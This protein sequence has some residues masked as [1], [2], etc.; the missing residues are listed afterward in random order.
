MAF[1]SGAM[2]RLGVSRSSSARAPRAPRARRLAASCAYITS[3][4]AARLAMARL[5]MTLQ[6]AGSPLRTI[7]SSWCTWILVM[8]EKVIVCVE[9]ALWISSKPPA[10]KHSFP[11]TAP[12]ITTR[13]AEMRNPWSSTHRWSAISPSR[14]TTSVAPSIV[15]VAAMVTRIRI[16]DLQFLNSGACFRPT[17]LSWSAT[18]VCSVGESAFMSSWRS[19]DVIESA[20]PSFLNRKKSRSRNR[21]SMGKLRSRIK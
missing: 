2:H 21:R 4:L 18:S 7:W 17:L 15:D 6:N 10:S 1:Q 16:C 13:P 11:N 20:S 8:V 5:R 14:L 3:P 12:L 9:C 19:G